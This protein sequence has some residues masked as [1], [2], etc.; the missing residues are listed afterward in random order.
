[1]NKMYLFLS[2]LLLLFSLIIIFIF[3]KRT[4]G[5]INNTKNMKIKRK[6]AKILNLVLFS[7]GDVYDQMKE[8]SIEFHS[9]Y[10]D[11]VDT[12]F[13]MYDSRVSGEYLLDPEKRMLYIRGKET[14]IPGIL[15]KTVKAFQYI[16]KLE[17]DNDKRYDYII[18]TN[19]ST[20]VDF[21]KLEELLTEDPIDYGGGWKLGFGKDWRDPY[22]G[23]HD[24][25]Y[26][27]IP[28]PSGTS[29]IFSREF[30]DKIMGKIDRIDEDVVDD[31]A[32]GKLVSIYLPGHTLYDYRPFYFQTDETLLKIKN[33]KEKEEVK[34]HIFYRN[35]ALQRENDLEI[36]KKLIEFYQDKEDE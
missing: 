3:P 23:I 16:G 28:Y 12:L 2:F 11:F 32:I 21:C 15:K 36:M 22:N 33:K 31:V 17:K 18:R 35:K 6:R 10:D 25:Q 20:F 29:M 9:K 27:D 19:I 7:H 14:Y 26:A 8:L 13:Y 24:S 4:T 1:M 30:F 34:K 5:R